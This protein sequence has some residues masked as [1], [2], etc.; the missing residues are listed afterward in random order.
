[1]IMPLPVCILIMVTTLIIPL[2]VYK[3]SIRVL[4]LFLT[5]CLIYLIKI[6]DHHL[7]DVG[8]SVNL[9]FSNDEPSTM[10]RASALRSLSKARGRN[11]VSRAHRSDQRHKQIPAR[12]DSQRPHH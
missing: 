5:K 12:Y 3:G 11:T 9:K 1:M 4:T 2:I 10:D 7:G 8:S 6:M